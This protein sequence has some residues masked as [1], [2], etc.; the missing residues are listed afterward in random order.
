[1]FTRTKHGANRVSADLDERAAS[2]PRR[3]TA[4]SRRRRAQRALENFSAG[5]T[6]VLVATDIAARGIDVDGVTHVINYELPHEPE[7]YVHR[8][9]RTAR[10][11]AAGVAISLCDAT[12][13]GQLR[14]IERLIRRSLPVAGDGM[15][16][17]RAEVARITPAAPAPTDR[18]R[19][20]A[21]RRGRSGPSNQPR[22]A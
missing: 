21:G 5:Q 13:R 17:A 11:G 2:P 18:A 4:T 14:A 15:Q 22:A 19:T 3:S 9:G 10:A 12:E 7:S 16:G 20:G 8:I 6:R 1:M